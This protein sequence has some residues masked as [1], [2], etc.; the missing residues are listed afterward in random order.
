LASKAKSNKDQLQS[1]INAMQAKIDI[2]HE[3][4]KSNLR[5]VPAAS[6]DVAIA[7]SLGGYRGEMKEQT[8]DARTA[9]I[10]S[11]AEM[12]ATA[13]SVKPHYKSAAQMLAR[14]T[15]GSEMR[16][17]IM[18]QLEYSGPAEL[19]SL[20]EL[21]AA[22]GDKD[23]GAALASKV[24]ALAPEK[25]PFDVNE[26][27]DA[28]VGDEWREI[29]KALDEIDRTAIDMLHLDREFETGRIDGTNLIE[30]ALR[31]RQAEAL[32]AED[33]DDEA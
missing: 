18:Q 2:K 21:A 26:L 11:A 3:T 16:S 19:T 29:N 23:L 13:A 10:R 24:F 30:Q 17:R 25:R 5:D 4:L 31:Q 33:D 32:Y 15:L 9:H 6:R 20:A 22:T 14:Y 8:A 7:S 27:A 1:L 12:R 28:L